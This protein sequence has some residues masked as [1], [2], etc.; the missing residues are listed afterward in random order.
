MAS[1]LDDC[2]YPPLDFLSISGYPIE[3]TSIDLDE[4]GISF[5]GYTDSTT[6]HVTSFM[7]LMS[8][9][10]VV[11]KDAMMKNCVA[12]F[13]DEAMDWF[14][15]LGR[16]EISSFTCLIQAFCKQWDPSYEVEQRFEDLV[17]TCQDKEK[18]IQYLLN[19]RL[20]PQVLSW[21]K[22]DQGKLISDFHENDQHSSLQEPLMH[23]TSDPKKEN[24]EEVIEDLVKASHDSI[25]DYACLLVLQRAHCD[26][27]MYLHEAKCL[28]SHTPFQ[29]SEFSDESFGE[30][31][32][33]VFVEKPL[34]NEKNSS[35]IIPSCDET[36]NHYSHENED[37][38]TL[39]VI[40]KH[41][42]NGN[43]LY[44]DRNPIY[45]TNSESSKAEF[46]DRI[47]WTAQKNGGM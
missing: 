16:K 29:I 12:T 35:V 15:N 10:D 45:D 43:C 42:W 14:E 3:F 46:S 2:L 4:H 26:D 32:R 40:G 47:S 9:L 44:F 6:L 41:I 37:I 8:D 34:E 36:E 7:K 22:L 33:E 11:H 27:D 24:C 30:L 1:S 17:E 18:K 39:F 38:S 21:L 28:V 19:V 13:D 20:T 23:E 31:E 5:H 25:E